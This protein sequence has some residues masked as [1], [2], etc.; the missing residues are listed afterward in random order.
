M[1]N[2]AANKILQIHKRLNRSWCLL[3]YFFIIIY[4]FFALSII[5]ISYKS[6]YAKHFASIIRT[7]I[8]MI[9]SSIFSL[10]H[11]FVHPFIHFFIPLFHSNYYAAYFCL[12]L[13]RN[14]KWKPRKIIW[15]SFKPKSLVKPVN[16]TTVC[17]HQ[18]QASNPEAN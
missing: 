2:L 17:R 13:W 16:L 18:H 12:K 4:Y 3:N 9:Q 8:F 5:K 15:K 14:V 1:F 7:L 6:F 10:N 11:A